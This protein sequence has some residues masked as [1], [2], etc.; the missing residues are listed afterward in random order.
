M[1]DTSMPSSLAGKKM[2][3]KTNKADHDP[4]LFDPIEAIDQVGR[5]PCGDLLLVGAAAS[6]CAPVAVPGVWIPA[7]E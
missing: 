7:E 2:R 5:V 4:E 6:G 1:M 3:G